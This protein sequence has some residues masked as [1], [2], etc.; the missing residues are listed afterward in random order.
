MVENENSQ[1]NEGLIRAYADIFEWRARECGFKFKQEEAMKIARVLSEVFTHEQIAQLFEEHICSVISCLRSG[2]VLAYQN[3]GLVYAHAV[4]PFDSPRW[5]NLPAL[6]KTRLEPLL[7]VEE[8][9][10]KEPEKEGFLSR[11]KKRFMGSKE[12]AEEQKKEGI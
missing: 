8:Q 2:S 10:D 5:D 4:L 3:C 1:I 9:S 6:L 12:A 7:E 11:V